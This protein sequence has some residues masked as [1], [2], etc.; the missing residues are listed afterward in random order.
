MSSKIEEYRYKAKSKDLNELS[1]RTHRSDVTLFVNCQIEKY[2]SFN[3]GDVVVD[4]GCGDGTLLQL[5]EKHIASCIGILPTEEE[6]ERVRT[7]FSNSHSN[8]QIEKGLASS[9]YLP[10]N[11]ATK[12]VCNGVLLLLK[13]DEI[14][15]A[16]EEIAR[17]S[18]QGALVYIGELPYLNELEGRDYDDSILKWLLWVFKNEG[19]GQFILRLNQT[20]KAIF[21]KEPFIIS[22][23]EHYYCSPESFITKAR[24]FGFLLKDNFPHKTI[25]LNKE[26]IESNSRQDYLFEVV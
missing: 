7:R 18:K 21:S 25:S 11:M 13:Q 1:G 24:N 5:I 2:M 9:T 17:I 14:D 26:I 16:L 22:T 8:I 10:T 12:V 4:I 20:L 23:K 6:V 19:I 3:E 15:L